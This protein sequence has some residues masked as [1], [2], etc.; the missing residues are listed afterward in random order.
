MRNVDAPTFRRRHMICS[1][2][3]T[4]G[5]VRLAVY[6]PLFFVDPSKF[7]RMAAENLAY[8]GLGPQVPWR[9]NKS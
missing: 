8:W 3:D 5:K 9:C 7:E 2:A 1:A 6:S 4:L